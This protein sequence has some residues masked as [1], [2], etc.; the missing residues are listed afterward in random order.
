MNTIDLPISEYQSLV[1]ENTL[2][3]NSELLEKVNRLIDLLYQDK[4]GLYLGNHT[5]DLTEYSVNNHW[6]E[7]E[8]S[9]DAV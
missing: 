6:N 7:S 4:Y 5:D 2:L 1:E 8:S 9:W 3:K